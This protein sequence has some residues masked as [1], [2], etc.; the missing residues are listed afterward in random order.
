MS[1]HKRERWY[2]LDGQ[3]Q[4]RSTAY[5]RSSGTRRIVSLIILLALVLVLIQQTSD[6]KKVEQ[7]ATAI[8]LLPNPNQGS[9]PQTIDGIYREPTLDFNPDNREWIYESIALETASQEVQINR[10]IW[11]TLLKRASP[12]TV[13][14]LAQRFFAKTVEPSEEDISTSKLS[15]LQSWFTDSQILLS[16]WSTIET[17]NAEALFLDEQAK[18][19]QAKVDES[20]ISRFIVWLNTHEELFGTGVVGGLLD[21]SDE[22][23]RGLKLALDSKLLEGVFDCEPWWPKERVTLLRT[24]QRLG[25][26]RDLLANNQT[27]LSSIPKV[28][29]PQIVSE[30][31][32]I[33]GRPIRL[34]GTIVKLDRKQSIEKSGFGQWSYQDVW[35]RPNDASNQPVCVSVPVS[36]VDNSTKIGE[37]TQVVVCGFFIKR[38]AYASERG[39]EVGPVMLAAYVGPRNAK[40]NP[41]EVPWIEFSSTLT[42]KGPAWSPP[43]DYMTPFAI[44]RNSFAPILQE[45]NESLLKSGFHGSSISMVLKPLLELERLSP[46]VQLLTISQPNWPIA[47]NAALVRLSG[48][49]TKVERLS[50]DRQVVPTLEHSFVY[51]CRIQS[52]EAVNSSTSSATQNVSEHTVVCMSVPS[53]WLMPDG[54]PLVEIRQPFSL[55]GV[56]LKGSDANFVWARTMEWRRNVVDDADVAQRIEGLIPQLSSPERFLLNQG[57]DLGWRDL[58]HEMQTEPIKPLS[59]REYEPFFALLRLANEAPY[60]SD[61]I[62]TETKNQPRKI[63]DLLESLR[64]TKKGASNPVVERVSMNMR[65]VRIS[66]IRVVDPV[67]VSLLGTNRYYQLDVMADVGDRSY[68]IKTDK[69]PVVYRK[70]YPVT[71]VS[72]SIPSWLQE[73]DRAQGTASQAGNEAETGTQV[74]QVW[75]PRMK[76]S[77]SGWFYRFWS[78][79]TQEITQ[80]MGPG[81]RQVGPLVVLDSLQRTA[82]VADDGVSFV[83]QMANRASVVIGVLGVVGIWWYVRK[84]TKN[85]QR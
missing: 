77:G 49:V 9:D 56:S 79:K 45:L 84:R 27:S 76:A 21:E 19:E 83:N 74:E 12:S 80:S 24:W 41:L 71:C 4:S 52:K 46:E 73:S 68:E 30:S 57:W 22:V 64:Q 60:I 51:R 7:V 42:R 39:A 65:V 6:T 2:S 47:D 75:Y 35:L 82:A 38:I 50:V 8:G 62:A 54:T 26:L 48:L 31:H 33:R 3:S 43:V 59:Q 44:L 69:D 70:E 23:L 81:K 28:N 40:S 16:Q 17:Q 20:P 11:E 15:E 18:Y 32:S 67:Q 61:N 78:Y 63:T 55:S 10:L 66:S 1:R 29:V 5:A 53:A 85:R 13:A 58:I 25:L 14:S 37:G 72:I 34:E 36:N